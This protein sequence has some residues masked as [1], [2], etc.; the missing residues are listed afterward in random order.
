MLEIILVAVVLIVDQVSKLLTDI[1]LTPLGTSFPLWDGVLHFTSA[2]NT[3]AAFSMFAGGRWIFIALT[4]IVCAAGI[5]F[6][7]KKRKKI[8]R[9][10]RVAVTLIVAG[11]LGNM[12]DRIV[13]GYVRDMIEFRFVHFAVFNVADSVLCIGAA[14]LIIYVLIFDGKK[15]AERKAHKENSADGE[16]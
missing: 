7:I 10:A 3:G 15:I 16:Q 12:I 5:V 8:T 9:L 4:V 2:H 13:L 11:A 14:L 1:Y 6:L